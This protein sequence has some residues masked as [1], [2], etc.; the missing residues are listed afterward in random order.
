MGTPGDPEGKTWARDAADAGLLRSPSAGQRCC[1]CVCF[2][3][4]VKQGHAVVGLRVLRFC[5]CRWTSSVG[6]SQVIVALSGL[7]N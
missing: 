7:L 5:F 4:F 6:R 1:S 2:R 3:Y